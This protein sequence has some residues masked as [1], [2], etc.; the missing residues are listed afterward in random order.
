MGVFGCVSGCAVGVFFECGVGELCEVGLFGGL[1]G[2]FVSGPW[3]VVDDDCVVVFVRI[4]D[5]GTDFAVGLVCA[6]FA[7]GDFDCLFA[8]ADVFFGEVSG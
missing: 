8:L 7:C 4:A 2:A 6:F 3:D 1:F 5:C